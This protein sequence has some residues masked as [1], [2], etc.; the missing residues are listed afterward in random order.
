M[1]HHVGLHTNRVERLVIAPHSATA[2]LSSSRHDQPAAYSKT[3]A[4][5]TIGSDTVLR[6]GL[7]VSSVPGSGRS[8]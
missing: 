4:P 1:D 7:T 8:V 5:P 3:D 2:H 6:D